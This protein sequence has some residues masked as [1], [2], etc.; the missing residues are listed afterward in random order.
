[1]KKIILMFISI[2]LVSAF[3]GCTPQVNIPDNK[4]E[5]TTEVPNIS[6]EERQRIDLYVAV[7]KG[8]FNKENGGSEFIAVRLDTL[9]GLGENAKAEVLKELASLSPN[10]YDFE[11]VKN[12]ST[13]FK[14][15]EGGKLMSSI[16]GS[17][18][19]IN[20]EQYNESKAEITGV[21]WFGSLGAVFPHY[22]ATYKNGV[23]ELKLISMAIS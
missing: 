7:M 12:D 9:D 22:E 6:A 3:I 17:L 14:L 8:A 5:P 23:W 10:I 18:L 15:D 2:M 20:L 11:K 16:N 13:K 1:M 19:Y 21:S 4:P